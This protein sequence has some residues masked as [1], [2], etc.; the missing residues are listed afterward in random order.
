[1]GK[2]L[3][4]FR[5]RALTRKGFIIVTPA[6]QSKE[7]QSWAA[8]MSVR[9]RHPASLVVL[10]FLCTG[11]IGKYLTD[12]HNEQLRKRQASSESMEV[13]RSSQVDLSSGFAD[14]KQRAL[15]YISLRQSGAPLAELATAKSLYK[16]A[17]FKVQQRLAVNGPDIKQRFPVAVNDH[18]MANLLNRLDTSLIEADSCILGGTLKAPLATS[19]NASP[20]QL[21][22]MNA[23]SNADNAMVRVLTLY[24]CSKF[25]T[26][27]LRPDPTVNFFSDRSNLKL[28]VLAPHVLQVCYIKPGG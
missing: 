1:M 24:N 11:V 12:R 14:Y 9:L 5:W 10:G 2:R 17:L 21:V 26:E 13:L 25:V 18:S 8:V 19:S 6:L 7:R 16:D 4:S 23:K 3:W 20:Q 28:G 22:C 15:D 27:L